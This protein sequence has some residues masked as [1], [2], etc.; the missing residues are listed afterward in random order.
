MTSIMPVLLAGGS[1]DRLW[2]LSRKSYPKQF[3][4]LTGKNSLFQESA[5]R[6]ISSDKLSFEPHLTLTNSEFRFIV[7]DQLNAVGIDPGPIIL[8]P[9][10][11]NTAP[12]I[13]SASIFAYDKN[14]DATLLVAPS[15]HIIPNVN[16]FHSAILKGL[17]ETQNGKIVTFGIKPTRPET[18]YGYLQLGKENQNSTFELTQ[19]VEK[20]NKIKAKKMVNDNYYLWNAGIF[21]F[22][23]KDLIYSFK[24]FTPNLYYT[25]KKALKE[26]IKDLDFI[27]LD[28]KEWSNC[29][30]IS[31]DYAVMEKSK[32]LSVVIFEKNWSDL[33]DWNA[34]WKHMKPNKHGVSTSSNAYAFDC[35]NTLL[36]SEST[37]QVIVGLDLNEILAISTPD[38]V[39]IAHKDKA[40]DI[41]KVLKSL[42]K[43]N[44]Y[45][46]DTFQK[47]HR[48]WGW[49]EI[50]SYNSIFQIKQLY[51]KSGGVLS[52]QSHHYRS[53]HWL[54]V[55][56]KAKVTIN[57]KVIIL[58]KGQS[59]DIP[60][61]SMHR[62][63]NN[64]KRPLI[65]IEIQMGSYFGEDD[66]IRY[67]DIYL[68]R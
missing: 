1:G 65:V 49:F 54:I 20:P 9:E 27:R 3:S 42:K 28:D 53:E 59:V 66:I 31:I 6:L 2:P 60:V 26:S 5:L 47:C 24:K 34:V 30:N 61:K 48:P 7:S 44:A 12:A 32:N 11:K 14:V 68:R 56:G 41:K 36:R 50:L 38:A 23:A 4:N 13:L 15:D 62:L 22:K 52:L 8:E 16:A 17:E 43:E 64:N 45:Q 10:L 63:E 40:Q 39:L 57:K 19:F 58:T 37:K 55:Q 25:V 51:V 29:E 33:G 67:E 35:K 21:L 18:G 46:T